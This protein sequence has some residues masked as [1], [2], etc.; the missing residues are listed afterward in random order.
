MAP[1]SDS[2]VKHLYAFDF[3]AVL[4][5]L[6]LL[7]AG[8]GNAARADVIELANGGRIE[9]RIVEG[10]GDAV[11]YVIETSA[12]R[13]TVARGQVKRV[14]AASDAE[15]EYEALARTA[16]NTAE[17]HWKLYEWCRDNKLRDLAQQHLT[18][19]LA[20]EPDHAQA[21]AILGFKKLDGEWMTQDQIMASRGMVRYEGRYLAPQQVEL[22]ER[23]KE[24]KAAYL[25]WRKELDRLR[26]ALLNDRYPDRAAEAHKQIVAIRDPLAADPLVALLRKE[27]DPALLRLW[28]EVASQLDAQSVVSLLVEFSLFHEIAEVRYQSLDYLIQSGRPG[29]AAPYLRHLSSTDNEIV[30]RAASALSQIGD[31]DAIGPLIDVLIT[32]HK[33]QVGSGDPGQ[34]SVGM[35][36]SGGMSMGMG[37]GA[38]SRNVPIRNP[39]VLTALVSLT[40]IN[41]FEYDQVAWRNWL[42][43][44]SRQLRVDLRR[45]E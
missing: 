34:M 22:L 19:L 35:S 15:K 1:R 29:L 37:G 16:P 32:T 11:N 2:R 20:L 13:V 45:D 42:S 33:V 17:A 8:V 41:D 25:D 43:A 5:G 28:L 18:R 31:P 44:Q 10:G 9:G 38:K 14:E 6:P 30:N 7:W 3:T 40:G 36:S 39:D 26:R 23:Q 4:M 21:R 12:G 27:K 24:A